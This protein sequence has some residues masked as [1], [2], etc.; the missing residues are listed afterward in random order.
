MSSELPYPS[1]VPDRGGR[2]LPADPWNPVSVAR[3]GSPVAVRWEDNLWLHSIAAAS[4]DDDCEILLED[5]GT[6]SVR[7]ESV[8]AIPIRPVFQVGHEVLAR[9]RSPAMFPGTIAG[10]SPQGYSINWYDG[11]PTLAVPLGALTFLE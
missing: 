5:G 1:D 8:I 10:Q 2:Q 4:N 3:G 6:S 9:W 7:R 11:S